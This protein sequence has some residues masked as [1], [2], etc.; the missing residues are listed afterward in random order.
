MFSQAPALFSITA[1]NSLEGLF[2]LVPQVIFAGIDIITQFA[3]SITRQLPQ[4]ISS[5]TQA[6]TSH[7][8][9]IKQALPP[10]V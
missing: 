5:G 6:V 4:I 2:T 1:L 3:Q 10:F 8:L 7:V 9:R